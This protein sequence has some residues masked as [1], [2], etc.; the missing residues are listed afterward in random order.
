MS[1]DNRG[2]Q[3]A[4]STRTLR[5]HL[6][7]LRIGRRHERRPGIHQLP[8]LLEQVRAIVCS[9]RL[10]REPVRQGRYADVA[11]KVGFLRGAIAE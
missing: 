9:F 11:G 2:F 7:D 8:A 10:V 5:P 1:A 4:V 6:H 3:D